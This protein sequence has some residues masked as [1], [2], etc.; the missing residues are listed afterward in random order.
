MHLVRPLTIAPLLLVTL[1]ACSSTAPPTP[2]PG[3]SSA[4]GTAPSA[5]AQPSKTLVMMTRSE[6]D[7]LGGTSLTPGA[8]STG[9][10]RRLFNA[11]LTLLDGDLR[12][13]PYLAEAL[14]QLNT[15]TWQV[16]PDGRMETTYRLRPD[17]VWHD[18]APLTA[19]D[20]VFAWQVYSTPAFGRSGAEPFAMM[21]EVV[22][23]DPRTVLIRWRGAYAEAGVL[24]G[25]VSSGVPTSGPTFAPLPRHLVER[26]FQEERETFLSNPFWT[27]EFVGAGPY[28]L[29]R[30][31][32]GAF[33]EAVAFDR[34]A[35]GRPKIDRVKITWSTD[36]STVLANLLSGE[37]HI[38]IDESIRIADGQVLQREWGARNAG[39]V[40]F[41]PK[42]WR[43][44]DFQ[45]RPEVASPRAIL[46]ERVRKAIA[47]TID[48]QAINEGLLEGVGIPADTMMYP[49]VPYQA[50]LERA[51]AKYPL[52]PRRAEALLQEAGYRKGADGFYESP[53]EGRLLFQIKGT[54]SPQNAA[55]RTILAAG[56]RQA[57][58]DTEE[59][60]F[61]AA[62]TQDGQVLSS[63]RSMYSTGAPAGT[64][65]FGLFTSATIPRAENRWVGSNRGGWSN[66][67]YD[68]LVAAVQ[69]T[70]EPNERARAIV[71][72][73]TTLTEQLGTVSLYFN[74]SVLA[75][76]AA[77]QGFN[78]RAADADQTWNLHEW[79]IR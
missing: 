42:N 15:P 8:T 55:E 41:I 65:A 14:P 38:P 29:D 68:R 37:V 71:Q 59:G 19:D 45:F 54:A 36:A 57:G 20:F 70:L 60:T 31:E 24:E 4:G 63:F 5:P 52:D 3:A 17:L 62:E 44:L 64:P 66:P 46:D 50:D 22:A 7:S 51:V 67:E 49:T 30:W 2:S 73:A 10:R 78:L 79:E 77:V 26:P 75:F 43:H 40:S 34:H 35:L 12:P 72:A 13:L 69:S 47:H 33:L 28:K 25:V 61:S 56:W 18:G 9:N 27:V 76:P 1:A 23:P 48:K 39:I 21:Q 58:L 32:S 6:P 74:P 16:F 11:G 53:G